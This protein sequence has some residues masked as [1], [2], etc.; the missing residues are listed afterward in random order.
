MFMMK[1]KNLLCRLFGLV[2]L[3]FICGVI[4]QFIQVVVFDTFGIDSLLGFF[5]VPSLVIV[6]VLIS[7]VFSHFYHKDKAYIIGTSIATLVFAVIAL[8]MY[9][10]G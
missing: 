6:P 1:N 8:S 3:A 4:F 2:G 9:P 10:I 7:T 5:M